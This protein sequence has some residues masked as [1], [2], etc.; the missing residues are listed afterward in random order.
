MTIEFYAQRLLNPFRGIINTVK[1]QSAEAV[2]TD[3]VNWDIYVSNDLLL[4]DLDTTGSIQIS[5]IRYGKWSQANGLKRGPL[6]PSEDF[7]YLEQ[8]GAVVLE[9]IQ[10]HHANVP[11]PFADNIELWLLDR[12]AMP[13][14]L[15]DSVTRRDEVDSE[16]SLSWRA[17]NL[18][19]KTFKS[20]ILEQLQ[21]ANTGNANAADYLTS[22]INSQT[23]DPP[24]AQWFERDVQGNA[25]AVQGINLDGDLHSRKLPAGAF[26]ITLLNHPVTDA[27]HHQLIDD[28][29]SWQA[30][31]L[32][33]LP[34]LDHNTRS[35]YELSARKQALIVEQQYRLYP[36]II[37][38]AA[39]NTAR[40]EAMLRNSQ[41]EP[42]EEENV[43]S[44][45]YLE[46]N[47]SS[48]E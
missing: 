33:L 39:I 37:D 9:Y 13:L 46:L 4:E 25:R 29:F 48:M 43:L 32:L 34:N 12:E 35:R 36:Q 28:F 20:G 15:L 45:W 2:S 14:A 24:A 31:W 40:V 6:Y 18:C 27:L 7:K 26:P 38:P 16:R 8:Q 42:E 47:P 19:R 5:D 22:F 1:Y 17:G 21:P 23:S 11:F 10:Q 30:P 3:G 41:P 44:T